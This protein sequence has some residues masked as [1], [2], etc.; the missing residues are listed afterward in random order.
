MTKEKIETRESERREC[1]HCGG[2][3]HR[4]DRETCPHCGAILPA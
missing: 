3:V 2:I 1:D 4:P